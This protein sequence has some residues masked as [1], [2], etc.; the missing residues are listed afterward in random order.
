MACQLLFWRRTA[1]RAVRQEMQTGRGVGAD[2]RR[3]P[4]RSSR[5]CRPRDAPAI[6]CAD[7]ACS[8]LAKCP[9]I[10]IRQ[11]YLQHVHLGEGLGEFDGQGC[12]VQHAL[13]ILS[14][15]LAQALRHKVGRCMGLA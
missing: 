6:A 12:W 14:Q 9:P 1:G 8:L 4:R 11:R 7:V 5:S 10:G 13:P 3:P 2:S 15:Q